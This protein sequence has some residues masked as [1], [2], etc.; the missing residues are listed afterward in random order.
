MQD[1]FSQP[2]EDKEPP[3]PKEGVLCR[4]L[5]P[6]PIAEPYDYLIPP[7][8]VTDNPD[9][10]CPGTVVEVPVG[11]RRLNGVVWPNLPHSAQSVGVSERDKRLRFVLSVRDIPPLP[12]ELL[13]TVAWVADYTLSPLGSVLKMVLSVPDACSAGGGDRRVRL[14]EDAPSLKMTPARQKVLESL[15]AGVEGTVA[16]LARAAGV[17]PAVVR[18]LEKAG[19]IRTECC[20]PAF[21]VPD[22]VRSGPSLSSDQQRAAGAMTE[23]LE[24]GTF[25]PILL[26]GVTGAGKTEV[27]FEALHRCFEQGKQALV[28]L[29]EIALSAQW[30]VRFRGRF[31]VE[32][33][34]W[35]SDLTP[36]QRRQTWRAVA[37]GR[38]PLVIGA[39]SALFL[40][41]PHL[42][43]IVVDEEHDASFKQDDGVA[44][45]G[46]DMAVVRAHEAAI[47]VVLASATP[48]LE[49]MVN[50]QKGRYQHL[51]L[52]ARHGGAALPRVELVDLRRDRPP[53]QGRTAAFLSPTLRTA[54]KNCLDSGEQALLFLNRRGY[55]PLTLCSNC[56]YRFQCR[57]C[58][59][60]LVEHRRSGGGE[61]GGRLSCHHCGAQHPRPSACP[62][63]AQD[64]TLVACG[65]GVE[66]IAEEAA[67]LFPEARLGLMTSDHLSSPAATRAM[68]TQVESGAVNLL[69]G[70]QVLAK[71]Y[72]F[73]MLTLVGVVDADLGLLGGD[74]RAAERSF[75]LLHQV[76][77]RAG[78]GA[79]AGRVVIQTHDPDQP[80]MQAL[81]AGARTRFLAE[82]SENR[83]RGG[84]PPY[85]RMVALILSSPDAQRL[86]DFCRQLAQTAPQGADYRTLGPAPAPIPLLRGRYRRRFLLQARR[87]VVVQKLVKQWLAGLKV[88]SSVR[89]MV[90]V[91]PY[92]FF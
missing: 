55:A 65:P 39:R 83:R 23:A 76:A 74:P 40:P 71:G 92:S 61:E 37:L 13:R 80:V 27:Y 19:V 48:A 36:A 70:T 82:E 89:M 4:V 68:V 78:R 51:V 58:T 21:D 32:P 75:Q 87:S 86:D 64:N 54:V 53:V 20:A 22:L 9:G 56:G 35:H 47:P 66:R 28:L 5:L 63:C 30:L 60:W 72:H 79:Q 38:A 16:D 85:G 34:Q 33:A 91:D 67:A 50:A 84:L 49:S 41:F 14:C 15:R 6:L 29:P 7:A 44:Y 62:S 3:P 42:G 69:V 12:A 26:D 24:F 1:F 45:H 43:L 90:D 18:G 31:G 2:P 8:I 10:L 17:S 77:G 88:P 73:P 52:P 46:R 57:S 81:A 59:A 11:P 25:C